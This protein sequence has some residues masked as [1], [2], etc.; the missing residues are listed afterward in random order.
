[1][2]T[3]EL[4]VEDFSAWRFMKHLLELAVRMNYVPVIA[5]HVTCNFAVNGVARFEVLLSLWIFLG[6]NDQGEQESH[7][8]VATKNVVRGFCA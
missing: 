2:E 5:A 3:C 6:D 8:C 4:R 7:E 1:M